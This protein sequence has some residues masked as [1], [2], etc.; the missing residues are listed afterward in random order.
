[1]QMTENMVERIPPQNL[2]AERSALGA[3]ML[4]SEKMILAKDMLAVEDFYREA[5]RVVFESLINLAQKGEAVD[6]ITVSEELKGNGMLE[7]IGGTA[8]LMSLANAVPTSA[9]FEYYAKIVKEKSLLRSLI[10][11]AGDIA[12]LGYD[13]SIEV[14]D[15]LDRAEREVF[16]LTKSRTA[17]GS[18]MLKDI[19]GQTFER[20]D[21]L[22]KSKGGVTG[23]STGFAD[24]DRLTAG[25]QA[26]DLIILAA[27][28]SMGK[29]T[30]ALNLASHVAV[31]Q[32]IPVVMFSLEMSSQQLAMKLL[33]SEAGVDN[34]R[35]NT[36]TLLDDDWPKLSMALGNLSESMMFLDDASGATVMD[37]R[38]KARRIK[39][40]YGLGLIVIDYLQ[41][42]QGRGKIENRQQEVSDISRS[43]KSLAKEL[44]VPIIALS[45]LS[46]AVEQRPDKHP[47]LADLRES[48]SLEQDA[49]I[50]AFLYRDDYYNHDTDRPNITDLIIAKHRNGPIGSAEFYFQ[51]ECGK[52]MSLAKNMG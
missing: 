16:Q 49:D 2:D 8:F 34:Q 32:K 12:A 46:R 44:D 39:S 47:G 35:V 41:L 10:R 45:Q 15:A 29:T 24:L 33:C 22:Y 20:I 14:D 38:A 42:M 50:V 37:I 51:K 9:N 30:F 17:G 43:L 18:V 19:L 6:V 52:F 21:E 31:K 28:P 11:V 7:K 4:D 3:M 36:G 23:V 5:H 48:G 1:M 27:R 26:S 25:L 40:K 13:G